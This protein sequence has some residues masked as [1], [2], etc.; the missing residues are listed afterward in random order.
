LVAG[1]AGSIGSEI[2]SQVAKFK[3][4]AERYVQALDRISE[5]TN[6]TIVQFGNVL[7]AAKLLRDEERLRFVFIGC[8]QY[9]DRMREQAADQGLTNVIFAG[10]FPLERMS[11]ILAW[12]TALLVSMLANHFLE[13]TIPSKL[14]AYF[15]V[16]RPVIAAA[17]GDVS[18]LVKEHRLGAVAPPGDPA[19]L[20]ATVWQLLASSDEERGEMGLR[21]R[22]LFF[23]SFEK[24]LLRDRY[25]KILEE[26]VM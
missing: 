19:R 23:R 5:E 16:E 4:A 21:S 26:I 15:A 20:A 24:Q 1:A 12:G 10:R 17:E 9:L 14:A 7:A 22:E 11:G 6:F 8:G 25:I 2:C 13:I 3:R 18:R